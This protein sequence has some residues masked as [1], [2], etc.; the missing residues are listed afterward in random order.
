MNW[1]GRFYGTSI[2]KKYV[3]A[4]TGL[5][6]V[7]FLVAHVLGNLLAFDGR[8]ESGGNPKLNEYGEFLR[9]EIV[10][11]WI[12]RIGLLV[13]AVLHAITTVKLTLENRAA[14]GERYAVKK[15]QA[16][17]LASRTMI[18]GGLLLLAFIVYHL[19]HFTVGAVHPGQFARYGAHD[20]Y[21]RVVESFQNPVISL[22]YLAGLVFLFVHL[23]HGIRSVPETLGL[24][25]PR[26]LQWARQGGPVVALII[27]GGFASVPLAVWFGILK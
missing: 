15:N 5:L 24:T 3:V 7:F 26:Y 1:L 4:V 8:G 13:A 19:L 6:L 20:V 9:F 10:L 12:F 16:S 27:A 17:T 2:G 22:V 21:S 11:L 25:H 18:W 23:V 14:R